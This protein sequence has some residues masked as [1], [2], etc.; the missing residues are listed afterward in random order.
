M[1]EGGLLIYEG[2]P[3]R[4][5]GL[6]FTELVYVEPGDFMMGDNELAICFEEGYYIG[7]YLVTQ[8]LYKEV[9]GLDPSRI[10]GH[11]HPVTMVSYDDIGDGKYS[12]LSKLNVEI[13]EKYPDLKGEFC[14]PSEAQWEYAARGGKWWDKPKLEY[15][16]GT[17]INDLAWYSENSNKQTMSVGL[18]LPNAL[19]IYD[20]S[21]NV[22]EWCEDRYGYLKDK[23]VDGSAYEEQGKLNQRVLRGGSFLDG[24]EYC[25]VTYRNNFSPDYRIISFGLRLVFQ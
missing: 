14:L 4:L 15:S 8:E 25:R 9:T 24:A 1:Q 7:K 17:E 3:L 11:H 13:K 5:F 18:K 20:M 2:K 6:D 10:K 23:P 16:G 12:F 21:G 22:W 19:G